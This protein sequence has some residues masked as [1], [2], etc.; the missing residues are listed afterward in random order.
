MSASY[1]HL[2][3]TA[4]LFKDHS[5]VDVF[6]RVHASRQRDQ[7]TGG[8]PTFFLFTY[9]GVRLANSHR[10]NRFHGIVFIRSTTQRSS[11]T[12]T[13]LLRRFDRREY[14][15]RNHERLTEDRRAIRPRTC[16]FFGYLAKE[17][18]VVGYAIRDRQGSFKDFR[19]ALRNQLIRLT[20]QYGTARRRSVDSHL[21]NDPGVFFRGLRFEEHMRGVS[22]AQASGSVRASIGRLANRFCL[23]RQQDDSAFQRTNARFCPVDASLL[24]DR[25]AL[26]EIHAGFGRMIFRL[27]IGFGR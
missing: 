13:H 14:P 18:S 10:A 23:T 12:I 11:G 1:G 22:S 4:R 20:F 27:S 24:N 3:N 17:F 25:T 19:R 2:G 26:Y 7:V 16:R 9:Q 6:V 15:F 5:Q 8:R 21:A